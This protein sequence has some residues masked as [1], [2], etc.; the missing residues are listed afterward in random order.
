M[1]QAGSANTPLSRVHVG[2]EAG[3]GD[4]L[5]LRHFQAVGD[6]SRAGARRGSPGR[7]PRR[8]RRLGGDGGGCVARPEARWGRLA[9]GS[10][11]VTTAPGSALHRPATQHGD[12]GFS[13]RASHDAALRMRVPPAGIARSAP[14]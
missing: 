13:C 9:T 2:E 14:R 3:H 8:R 4:G 7:G 11:G 1:R 10:R 12:V 6:G 5:V